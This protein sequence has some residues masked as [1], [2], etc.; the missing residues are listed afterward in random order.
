MDNPNDTLDEYRRGIYLKVHGRV[1]EENLY[2]FFRGKLTSP[3]SVD[4]RIRGLIEA[5]YLNK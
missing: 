2:N 4:A 3:A 5:D 1:I